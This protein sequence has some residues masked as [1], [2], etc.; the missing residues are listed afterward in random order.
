MNKI[1][2][3]QSGFTIIELLIVI[4]IIAVLAAITIVSYST[5]TGKANLAAAQSSANQVIKKA[6]TYKNE[7]TALGGTGY[8]PVTL[9]TLNGAT[10]DKSYQVTGVTYSALGAATT[11][12]VRYDL[13]GV[14]NAT[15]AATTYAGA[16]GIGGTTPPSGAFITG[17][18]VYFW[19]YTTGAITTNPLSVGQVSGTYPGGSATVAC[20]AAGS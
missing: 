7:T 16:T 19:D 18:K 17:A 1:T 3:R 2:K 4:A 14:T 5:V 6:E 15:T 9:A 8:Y 12:G 11:T 20:F 10:S 13:C